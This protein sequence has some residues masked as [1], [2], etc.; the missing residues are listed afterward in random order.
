MGFLGFGNYNKPGPG[1]SKD[2]PPKAAPVRFFEIFL[3]KFWKFVQVNLLFAVPALVASALAVLLF[4]VGPLNYSFSMAGMATVPLNLLILS[5][6]PFIFLSPFTAGLTFISRNFSREEHAFIW[7]DFVKAVKGNIKF[8]L[9]NGV[10]SYFVTIIMGFSLTY[11]Y[12]MLNSG[13]FYYLPMALCLAFALLFLFAQFY[14][15][16]MFVTFELTFR[17]A[18]KNAFIFAALGIGR[19]L[20]LV[21]LT[22]GLLVGAWFLISNWLFTMILFLLMVFI[23]FAFYNYLVTFTVYPVIDKYLIKPYQD[24]EKGTAE[25]DKTQKDEKTLPGMQFDVPEEEDDDE[26]GYVYVNGRM[27]KKSELN[28]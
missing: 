8:F 17:Q 13:W 11:Y 27:V 25:K 2:E 24:R 12:S 14:L 22:A 21:V 6:I 10:I 3:R 5:P 20:L 4:I 7:T 18:Y 19:N 23:L 1:V 16:V 9:L 28:K 26:N 15:P